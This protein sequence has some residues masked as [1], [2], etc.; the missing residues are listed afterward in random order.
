MKKASM[1]LLVLMCVFCMTFSVSAAKTEDYTIDNG[2]RI[3]IPDAYEY[4]YTINTVKLEDGTNSL[5]G[6]PTDLFMDQDGYLYVADSLNNRVVK[7]TTDGTLVK[8]YIEAG[9]IWFFNPQGVF[10]AKNGDIY[11]SDTDNGRI[12]QIDQDGNL[13]REFL[14]PESPMLAE[15]IS[16]APTKISLN[17]TGELYVLMGENIMRLDKNNNFRGFMGQSDVGFDFKVWLLRKVASDEQ[18]KNIEKQTAASYDNFCL[19]KQ[20]LIYAVSRDVKEGQIKILNS[21]G[22]NIYRKIGS[23]AVNWQAL[24][25]VVNN[26]F[27]GNII[28]KKFSYG[29]IVDTKQPQFADICVDDQ[30]II[31]VIEQNNCRLYQ[32]DASGNLLAVFGGKGTLQGEFAIPIS[33]VVD[34]DGQIFVLDQSYG[35]I[36][37]LKPTAFART[38]QKATVAYD[39]GDYLKADDLW[40]QV[41]SVGE[42][43]PMAHFG[44]GRTAYKNGDWKTAMEYFIYSSDRKEYSNAFTEYRY[45]ILKSRFW[46]VALLV[47]AAL[48]VMIPGMVL[49]FRKSKKVLSDFELRRIDQLGFGQSLLLGANVILRPSRTFDAIKYGRGRINTKVPILILIITFAVRIFFIYTVHYPFQDVP[50]D[51]ANLALEFIKVL[52]PVITWIVV[53]YLISSQFSGESTFNENLIAVAYSMLPY[54]LVNLLATG[55]SQVMCWNESRF[56]ALM[57][58]GV[59]IWY[60]ILFIKAVHRLNDYSLLRTV[61]VC[62]ISVVGMVLCWFILLFAYSLAVSLIQFFEKIILEMQLIM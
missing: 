45:E 41:F 11:I 34:D 55:L 21:V 17:E 62:V 61:S 28:S 15:V 56:F 25:S 50:P 24:Q 46:L 59:T 22:N 47:V 9:G 2:H 12:V 42:A 40:M 20:G 48:A 29:E 18:K 5:L 16:Y 52:L 19:N 23:A 43:Y 4:S 14:L 31:T 26:F 37:V 44:A 3:A 7:I 35:T 49:F 36:T 51:E 1:I 30:G 8:E 27:S 10:V 39:E 57:V 58:N 54:I 53:T 13:L 38:V 60:V 6:Q 33:L 32:Y